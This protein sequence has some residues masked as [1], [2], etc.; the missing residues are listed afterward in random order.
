MEDLD[1]DLQ[2]KGKTVIVTGGAAGI[3]LKTVE[4]LAGEGASVVIADITEQKAAAAADELTKLGYDVYALKV[5]VQNEASVEHMVGET[6]KR[7]GRVDILVNNAGIG[8]FKTMDDESLEEWQRVIDVNLTG[9]HLC[10][11]AVFKQM[12]KQMGGKIISLGSLGGQI[13]GMRVTPGYVASKAG[14]MGL[15]KSYARNGAQYGIIANAVAPGPTETD[16]ARG[17]YSPDITL[18]GRLA[19][20]EDIAKVLVFLASSM[21]DYLTGVTIDV[22]GGILMR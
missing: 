13:G 15:T 9:V 3:G 7:F 8:I 18:L 4:I 12:K 11:R 5:D 6:V 10:T 1:M 16:M 21:A 20:P 14:V 19:E 2:V 22:N 17:I